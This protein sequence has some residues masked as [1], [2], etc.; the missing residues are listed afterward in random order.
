MCVHVNPIPYDPLWPSL[1][2]KVFIFELVLI[3][4][5]VFIFEVALIFEVVFIFA[6][7][8]I[9]DVVFIFEVVKGRIVG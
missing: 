6:V 7:V 5:V 8:L 1:S 2:C 4:E 9:F 3:F